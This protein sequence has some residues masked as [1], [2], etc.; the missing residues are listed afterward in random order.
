[1]DEIIWKRQQV[2]HQKPFSEKW[3]CLLSGARIK[4]ISGRKLDLLV[5]RYP[6]NGALKNIV[7]VIK[8]ANFQLIF[9]GYKSCQSYLEKPTIENKDTNKQ[10][11]LFIDQTMCISKIMYLEEKKLAVW[12]LTNS[13]LH[14]IKKWGYTPTHS[15][16]LPPTPIHFHLLTLATN[17]SHPLTSTPTHSIYSH[18][19]PPSFPSINWA[20]INPS[21]HMVTHTKAIWNF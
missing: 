14:M 16:P 5:N 4:D 21:I 17:N 19:L 8:Q 13:L 6:K 3:Q 2:F 18:S 7:H 11:Q 9:I 10:L 12:C 15:H 20:H 1:M